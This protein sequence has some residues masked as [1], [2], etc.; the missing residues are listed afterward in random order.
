MTKYRFE[1]SY[2]NKNI[3]QV[4]EF[5][6]KVDLDLGDIY[7]KEVYGFDYINDEKPID[8]FKDLFRQAYETMDCNIINIKGGKIE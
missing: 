1:I 7:L 5:M 3:R 6:R 2:Q 8:Y 4:C